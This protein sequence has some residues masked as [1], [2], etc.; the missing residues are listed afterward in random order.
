MIRK[1]AK[2]GS[3]SE[4]T[5]ENGLLRHFSKEIS[6]LFALLLKP[7]E[8]SYGVPKLKESKLQFSLGVPLGTKCGMCI[9]M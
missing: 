2:H 3:A 6:K 8:L 7:S 4:K 9:S 5:L 1:T